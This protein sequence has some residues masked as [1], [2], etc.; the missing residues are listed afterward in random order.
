MKGLVAAFLIAAGLVPLAQSRVD[1]IREGM[2]PEPDVSSVWTGKVVKAFSLGYA[3]LLADLYWMRAVQYYGR[4]KLAGTG[5]ADLL[6]LLNTAAE[7]DPRFSIVYRY[8]AVFLSEP[9]PIGAGLPDTGVA[10]LS[11]G[12]DLNPNNWQLRQEEGLFMFFYQHDAKGGSEVLLRASKIEGAPDWMAGLAA[13]VLSKGG[14]LESSLSMWSIIYEQSE[15]GILRDNA[16]TQLEI[17]QS[18]ILAREVE[19]KV[20]AYREATGDTAATLADLR[21]KG[22]I[23]DFRDVSGVEFA[24]DQETGAVTVS[25]KSTLWRR[26]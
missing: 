24:F 2:G 25:R 4:Q 17:V 1:R 6:P 7:L 12:A 19:K 13:Q 20:R 14:E 26:D 5:Y 8:G 11:K 15:P 3:D 22:V 16:R 10:L 21:H 9:S 18:R 23:A